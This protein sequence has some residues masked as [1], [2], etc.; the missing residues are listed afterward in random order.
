MCKNIPGF[1]FRSKM[2]ESYRRESFMSVQSRKCDCWNTIW[3]EQLPY[4]AQGQ[5]GKIG[6]RAWEASFDV[7][8]LALLKSE[9]KARF[10][11]CCLIKQRDW[12]YSATFNTSGKKKTDLKCGTLK[13]RSQQI[14]PLSGVFKSLKTSGQTF[15]FTKLGGQ[16]FSPCTALIRMQKSKQTKWNLPCPCRK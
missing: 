16:R 9:W 5:N 12:F 1:F 3:K 10:P 11:R 8:N 4:K 14:R 13:E 7:I 2:R 6:M 15:F